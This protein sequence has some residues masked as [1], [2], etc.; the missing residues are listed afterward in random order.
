MA[1]QQK[2]LKEQGDKNLAEGKAFLAENG[3]KKGVKTLPSGLQ[4]KVLAEGSGKTPRS[5][6]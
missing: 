5:H 1:A 2:T 4:Y 6:G 3:K